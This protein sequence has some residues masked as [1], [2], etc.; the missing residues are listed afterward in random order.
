MNTDIYFKNYIDTNYKVFQQ[1]L[2]S[3]KYPIIGVKIPIIRKISKDLLTRYSLE[4][5]VNNIDNSSFENVLLKGICIAYS[6]ECNLSYINN[7]IDLIDNWSLCD[8]FCSTLKFIKKD[9]TTYIEFINSLDNDKIISIE[10]S[11]NDIN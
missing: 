4:Y 3:T 9:K 8:T 7:Y 6:N 1:K 2:C 11:I 10:T 5:L